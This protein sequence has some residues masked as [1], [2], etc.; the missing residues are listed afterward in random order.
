VAA[1][2]GGGETGEIMCTTSLPGTQPAEWTGAGSMMSTG[3][4]ACLSSKLT[5]ISPSIW[6]L[7]LTRHKDCHCLLFYVP[8][9]L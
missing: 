4:E 9:G 3:H 1:A 7:K 2:A 8:M 5:S 6:I